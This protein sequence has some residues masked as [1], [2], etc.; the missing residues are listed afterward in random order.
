MENLVDSY[1]WY[2]PSSLVKIHISSTKD[3]KTWN[4]YDTVVSQ[5]FYYRS[6]SSNV[7]LGSD[8]CFHFCSKEDNSMIGFPPNWKINKFYLRFVHKQVNKNI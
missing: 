2:L 3:N 4:T 8:K 7:S 5:W 6:S 1:I